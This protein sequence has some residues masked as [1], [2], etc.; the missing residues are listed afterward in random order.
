MT[1]TKAN[2]NEQQIAMRVSVI[3]IIGNVVLTVFK[4]AAGFIAGSAAMISDAVHSGSDVLSTFIVIIGVKLSG[5]QSD[6]DHQYGHERLECVAALILS[7]MLAVTGGAIGLS[8][9]KTIFAGNYSE[10]RVPGTLALVAAII[11]IVSKEAMYQYTKAVA[12]RINSGALKADAWHHRSDAL[13]SVGSFI[14][15]LG[16]KLG[17]PVFGPLASVVICI[18][19]LKVAVDIFRD[20]IGKMTDKACDDKTV[21]E[22]REFIIVQDGVLGIDELKT[23][24]FGNKMYVDVEIAVDGN[25][26]LNE[27]HKIAQR[28]HDTIE[29]KFPNTK[30]CMVHV[31]PA[32][33][34]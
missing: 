30:H 33:T 25:M 23:R 12:D 29:E 13:S 15:I 31:N 17:L 8:G 3:T 7:I 22:I 28:V 1:K 14:G 6:R 21:S 19:I 32:I 5:K 9:L 2:N 11:S 18:F 4:L 24:L 16:A 26:T 34:K 20:S 10:L 27:S